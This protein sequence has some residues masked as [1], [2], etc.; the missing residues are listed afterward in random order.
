MYISQTA[1]QVYGDGYLFLFKVT[2]KEIWLLLDFGS[3]RQGCFFGTDTPVAHTANIVF[4]FKTVEI[5]IRIDLDVCV[6][7]ITCWLLHLL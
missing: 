2:M 1:G 4:A 6:D 7:I 3:Q 5:S